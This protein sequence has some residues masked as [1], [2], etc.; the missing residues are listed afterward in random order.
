MGGPGSGLERDLIYQ[1]E[2]DLDNIA[3]TAVTLILDLL[4]F[5]NDMT[6]II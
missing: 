4:A 2:K 6:G 3:K 1:I 5:W